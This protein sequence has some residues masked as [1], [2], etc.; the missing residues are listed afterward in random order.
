[1]WVK[2][3]VEGRAK[4]SGSMRWHLVFLSRKRVERSKL[5][6]LDYRKTCQIIDQNFS[7]LDQK[8]KREKSK[9]PKK[10]KD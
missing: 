1:L 10:E 7:M 8:R 5:L 2:D 3:A 6:F 4:N 9:N